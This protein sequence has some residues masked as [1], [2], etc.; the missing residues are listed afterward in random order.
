MAAGE[1]D[2][3]QVR[4]S[5]QARGV[6][7]SLPTPLPPGAKRSKKSVESTHA[8]SRSGADAEQNAVDAVGFEPFFQ[9]RDVAAV[10]ERADTD[11]VPSI[12]ALELD[13]LNVG[14]D[15]DERQLRFQAIGI[16]KGLERARL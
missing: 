5:Y 11:S 16:V 7:S 3:A 8:G 2:H 6:R 15:S 1:T 13:A 10:A 9:T 14:F 12:A 4:L